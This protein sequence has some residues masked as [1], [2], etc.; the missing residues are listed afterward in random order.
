MGATAVKAVGPPS[1]KRCGMSS[2]DWDQFDENEKRFLSEL[3]Q[4][5]G[6]IQQNVAVTTNPSVMLRY[7]NQQIA[8]LQNRYLPAA[9]SMRS[10]GALSI[11]MIINDVIE[12]LQ[13]LVSIYQSNVLQQHQSRLQSFQIRQQVNQELLN[14]TQ[15]FVSD[16]IR[17]RDKAW[18]NYMKTWNPPPPKD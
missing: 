17:A 7:V 2:I 13:G 18:D 6:D 9:Y 5:A 1:R 3:D 11:V 16:S 8:L 12:N 10:D 4:I 15:E 14:T